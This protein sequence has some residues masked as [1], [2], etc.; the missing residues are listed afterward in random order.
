MGIVSPVGRGLP[1]TL[2]S[3]RRS[4]SG[5]QPVSLFPSAIDPP[6]PVGQ[7]E[8]DAADVPRTHQL[9][10]TAAAEALAEALV[11][12]DAV[13][14]GVTT[15]GM[16]TTEALLLAG[17]SDPQAF[18]LHS[19]GSVA[20]TV[21]RSFDISGPAF[22]VST[23][24][25]SGTV[26]L[27][28]A[29]ELLRRG[30]MKRV[31]AGGAD[32]LCRLTYYGFNALQLIDPQGARPLD[33]DRN[34]M[35]VA[36]GA[37]MLLLEAHDHPPANARAEILG[38]GLSCDAYHPAAPHPEGDG[39]VAAMR[40]ALG[41]AR[42]AIDDVDYISLHGTGTLHNDLSEARA[43]GRLFG[44]AP[45]PLSSI[46]GGSGHSLAAAG[47][48][49]AVVSALCIAEG[50]LPANVG[51]RTPDPELGLSPLLDPTPAEVSTVLSNSF[52][53]GG[54]NAAVLL[55]RP[56]RK[57]PPLAASPE[58]NFTILGTAC[59]SGAGDLD[60]TFAALDGGKDCRG[61]ADLSKVTGTLPPN[62]VRRLK[63]LPRMVLA[64]A[65]AA[66]GSAAGDRSPEGVFFGT[67]W[68]PLSET[69]DFI[70]DMLGAD[71]AFT[72]PTSFVGSVQNAPA[73]QVA[74]QFNSTGA[75]VTA[76]GGD[77]AFEQAL[78]MA[79]L[80]AGDAD[81]HRSLV[82]IG[83]DE[84]QSPLSDLFDESVHRDPVKS[85]GGGAFWVR[86]AAPDSPLQ[87]RPVFFERAES[88]QKTVA[89]LVARLGDASRIQDLFGVL[90][91]GIPRAY[92]S[93]GLRQLEALLA[94][95]GC[96]APVIDY[97]SLLGEHASATAVA[98]ALAARFVQ[99]G[100]LPRGATADA[101]VRLQPESA[102][103]VGLGRYVTA[104]EICP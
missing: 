94:M 43:V 15:G 68:G 40:S 5:I 62:T 80:S 73:G 32:S 44:G 39:G 81:Q 38:V 29:F 37:A 23:A 20:E 60:Q 3:L 10:L 6:L 95:S 14:L 98:A 93:A 53:F 7:V 96:R 8:M 42:M 45:P 99:T 50:M 56:D 36:E 74:M 41:G 22:T 2:A 48:M 16:L 79:A 59:I 9:A 102:L 77:Y 1:A 71:E 72:S 46:K 87:V 100:R 78:L 57:R 24:C 103:I 66:H 67:G 82:I 65:L 101:P 54:N 104:I 92:R 25:S 58:A 61:T 63:R 52:G 90:M 13:V 76:A 97:R 47:A 85:D 34:G 49:E 11:S 89:S 18:S 88:R 35:T 12:P 28:V 31:L 64:L 55:A 51:C 69:Y 33:K 27:K 86:P 91:V 70:A 4:Q 75:N 17:K 26:A 21:A 84:Y 83:A 19:V 30:M